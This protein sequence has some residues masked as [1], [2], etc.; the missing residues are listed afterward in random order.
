M[1]AFLSLVVAIAAAALAYLSWRASQSANAISSR[2]LQITEAEHALRERQRQARAD[3]EIK[4][5]PG[6]NHDLDQHGTIWTQGSHI[7][8]TIE[9]TVS[10]TGDRPTGRTSVDVWVPRFTG[11]AFW[12]ESAGG[13]EV[14][15]LARAAP[16]PS[17]KLNESAGTPLYESDR[18]TRQL[19]E[20]PVDLPARLYLRT[21]FPTQDGD[22]AYPVDVVV[23]AEHA[24]A[25]SKARRTI[26]IRRRA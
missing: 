8:T 10:N 24:D 7:V 17:V 2:A 23:R 25:E 16:D 20:I 1:V 15:G 4:I 12:A 9:L 21:T 11:H 6:A 26:R 14:A 19:D 5:S 13:A 22:A 3:L 18:L